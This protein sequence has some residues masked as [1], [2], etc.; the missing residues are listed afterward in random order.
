MATLS[1]NPDPSQPQVSHI[2]GHVTPGGISGGNMW[3]A[4]YLKKTSLKTKMAL[5]VTLLFILFISVILHP[6]LF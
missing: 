4:G 1:D 5:A 6:Y 3:K 2:H